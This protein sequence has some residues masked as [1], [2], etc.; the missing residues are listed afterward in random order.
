GSAFDVLGMAIS[1]FMFDFKGVVASFKSLNTNMLGI[2]YDEPAKKENVTSDGDVSSTPTVVPII[3]VVGTVTNKDAETKVKE[4]ERL[5]KEQAKNSERLARENARN[6]ESVAREIAQAK[7][8]QERIQAEEEAKFIRDKE[9][10]WSIAEAEFKKQK[11]DAELLFNE[12]LQ[13]IKDEQGLTDDEA[14]LLKQEYEYEK[15]MEEQE[16]KIEQLQAQAD[17]YLAQEDGATT[18]AENMAKIA[19]L[20][21]EQQEATIAREKEINAKEVAQREYMNNFKEN[22]M[23][24]GYMAL[25]TSNGNV[26]KA[27]KDF[28]VKSLSQIMMETGQELFIRGMKDVFMG[29][30]KQ[31]LVVTAPHIAAEGVMQ[32]LRGAQSIAAGLALGASGSA[33]G[34][35]V[36]GDSGSSS[37]GN[38]DN[39]DSGYGND[40]NDRE[41]TLGLEQEKSVTIYTDGDMKDVML[42]ML[43]TLNGLAKDYDNI[44]IVSR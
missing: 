24:K 40:I 3:P 23:R 16:F 21:L 8:E 25:M 30:A 6:A 37:G 35:T 44:E 13:M 12:E 43:G 15:F 4:Q 42:S 32:N 5:A 1:L 27:M 34:S 7:A 14:V 31:T 9:A 28:A 29:Q 2:K 38:S 18:H 11:L 19:E 39:G 33:L 36:G 41:E 20:K 17:F 26:L 10:N 22:I